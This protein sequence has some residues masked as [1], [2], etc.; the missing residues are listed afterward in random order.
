MSKHGTSPT[1][2]GLMAEFEDPNALVAATYRA[3]YEG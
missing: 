1:V 2:H 3:H